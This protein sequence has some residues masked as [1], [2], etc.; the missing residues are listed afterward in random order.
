MTVIKVQCEVTVVVY[1]L[2][3]DS[4]WLLYVYASVYMCNNYIVEIADRCMTIV[5]DH[6]TFRQKLTKGFVAN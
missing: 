1:F 2:V 4:V 5:T 3:I 6:C